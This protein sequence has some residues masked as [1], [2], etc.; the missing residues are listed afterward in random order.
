MVRQGLGIALIVA[1]AVAIVAVVSTRR[2]PS[3]EDHLKAYYGA[4]RNVSLM[5]GGVRVPRLRDNLARRWYIWRGKGSVEFLNEMGKH[6]K[7]LEDLGYLETR[8]FV[9]TNRPALEVAANVRTR[10]S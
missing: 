5:S 4:D 1:A 8:L 2:E 9:C 3:V 10:A 6:H 7:A